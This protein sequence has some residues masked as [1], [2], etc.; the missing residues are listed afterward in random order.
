MRYAATLLLALCLAVATASCHTYVAASPTPPI[1]DAD[2]YDDGPPPPPV[3][4]E[5]TP[6]PRQPT[7]T[8][9]PESR[10]TLRDT[11]SPRAALVRLLHDLRIGDAQHHKGISVFPLRLRHQSRPHFA[12]L[13]SA[14]TRRALRLVEPRG[15]VH[16]LVAENRDTRPVLL[17]AG[18]LISGGGRNRAVAMDLIVPA[19]SNRTSVPTL[20]VQRHRPS[21][22]SSMRLSPTGMMAP[23]PV[24]FE[25]LSH[26]GRPLDARN[27]P[28]RQE[29]TRLLHRYDVRSPSENLA[30][31][32]RHGQLPR[33]LGCFH[34]GERFRFPSDTVGLLVMSGEKV[35]AIEIF[36]SPGTF[37]ASRRKTLDAALAGRAVLR[38]ACNAPHNRLTS[39][40]TAGA[41]LA[42]LSRAHLPAPNSHLRRFE[43]VGRAQFIHHDNLHLRG[44]M[45]V[46]QGSVVHLGAVGSS[47]D[48]NVAPR[49]DHKPKPAPGPA[50]FRK[51]RPRRLQESDV[52]QGHHVYR[53]MKVMRRH[54]VIR[55]VEKEDE[56]DDN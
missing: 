33:L 15:D 47:H 41:A 50:G 27:I 31:V 6:A 2:Q 52:H 26:P 36:P 13:E 5:P 28:V 24:R 51:K 9:A 34:R 53:P 44:M 22:H 19:R 14:S 40:R 20:A 43:S 18:D 38:R 45:L 35:L 55:P 39:R 46:Y 49:P 23:A 10:V 11:N 42:S 1:D 54:K 4:Q 32:Y 12:G 37:H 56:D 30:D 8:P 3:V 7:P 29:I 16:H 17:V 21:R 25:I 48:V